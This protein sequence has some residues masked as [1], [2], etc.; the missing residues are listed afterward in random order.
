VKTSKIFFKRLFD[1]YE[2][3]KEPEEKSVPIEE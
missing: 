3:A 1:V 2:E